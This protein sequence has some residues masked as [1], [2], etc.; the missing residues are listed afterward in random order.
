MMQDHVA[1]TSQAVASPESSPDWWHRTV[2][3]SAVATQ[4]AMFFRQQ[5]ADQF[6]HIPVQALD[7]KPDAVP[8]V[9]KIYKI[10]SEIYIKTIAD[11]SL[12]HKGDIQEFDETNYFGHTGD[13]GKIKFIINT[14]AE[15]GF[16]EA[17]V[18]HLATEISGLFDD[19]GA[20][21]REGKAVA[22]CVGVVGRLREIMRVNAAEVTDISSIIEANTRI[23]RNDELDNNHCLPDVAPKTYEQWKIE[24]GKKKGNIVKFMEEVWISWI[25]GGLL[26][27]PDLKR[28][29]IKAYYALNNWLGDNQDKIPVRLR[30]LTKSEAV[31][32]ELNDEERL[33]RARRLVKKYGGWANEELPSFLLEPVREARRL[34]RAA[35]RRP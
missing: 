1:F 20:L 11:G 8:Q 26:T 19:L 22:E 18:S 17:E 24:T 31:D 3:S 5:G 23:S 32:R 35:D 10:P 9:A 27:M 30:V 4:M 21:H 34:V 25:D 7:S 33:A 14:L 12:K 15:A 2:T 29:D 6:D 16:K 28:L 13:V